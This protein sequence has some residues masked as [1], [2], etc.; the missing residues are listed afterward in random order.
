LG[1]RDQAIFEADIPRLDVLACLRI[2]A[3]LTAGGARL[4]TGSL[5]RLWPDG[6]RTR[7]TTNRIS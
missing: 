5:A 2:A 4:A 3:D 6:F 7:W 1:T